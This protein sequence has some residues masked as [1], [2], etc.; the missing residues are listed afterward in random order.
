MRLLQ[1]Q[2][3][4]FLLLPAFNERDALPSLIRAAQGVFQGLPVRSLVVVVDDGSTDD[5]S[6]AA[7]GAADSADLKVIRHERNLG[8]GAALRTGFGYIL[9][10]SSPDDIIVTMD[11]DG[12]QSPKIIPDMLNVLSEGYD[13]VIASRFAAGGSVTGVS[14]F[15]RLL[16]RIAGLVGKLLSGMPGVRDY[17]S[18][19]RAYR[20]SALANA[21]ERA[22]GNLPSTASFA[23]TT[24]ILLKLGAAGARAAEVP[25]QLRY[26]LKHGASKMKLIQT[27]FSYLAI[28]LRN[29]RVPK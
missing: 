9:P 11:A 13:V 1:G 16:S 28:Y 18:G 17:S 21:W 4:V 23:A 8:L 12:T 2:T 20:A 14:A 22:G 27:C 15:R 24:E 3:T 29:T 10:Q 25:L 19:Y 26:D 7:S 5:T 6:D